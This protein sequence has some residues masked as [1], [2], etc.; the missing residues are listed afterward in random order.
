MPPALRLAA[1]SY[2]GRLDR[3]WL[4]LAAVALAAS[5]VAGVSGVMSSI[6]ASVKMRLNQ[7]VGSADLRVVPSDTGASFDD[8][9]IE[10]VNGWE[11]VD[12][13][14]SVFKKGLG[15]A[16]ID[17]RMVEGE[18]GVFRPEVD[19]HGTLTL[20]TGVTEGGWSDAGVDLIAG[21]MPEAPGE[22]VVDSLTAER[23]SWWYTHRDKVNTRLRGG[24]VRGF[25]VAR[26][27]RDTR[28]T[29]AVPPLPD[30]V[31][32][33]KEAERL[34]LERGLRIGDE[35]EIVY[36]LRENPKLQVVGVMKQ[37]PLGG[38]PR[39]YVP[40]E[41]LHDA[42]REPG[43]LSEISVVLTAGMDPE[44]FEA[45]HR[46][47]LPRGVI[48][49]TTAK[50]TSGVEKNME[51][52]QLGSILGSMLALLSAAFI[53]ATGLTT[54]LGQRQRE[55][56]MLRCIG[57][58]RWQ[59]AGAQ[60]LIGAGIGAFGALIG[61]PVGLLGALGMT[62]ILGP[63]I[64]SGLVLSP[65]FV[66]LS[67]VG[68]V[69][70][71]LLGAA[72]PAWRVARLSPLEGMAMRAQPAS[73]RVVAWT[74]A[75]AFGCVGLTIAI[76]SFPSNTQVMFWGYATVGLPSMMTG[77]FLLG[78]PAVVA[79]AI[80]LGPLLD[81]LLGLPRGLLARSVRATPFRY[82][83]TAGAMMAGLGLMVSIWTNGGAIMNDW[84]GRIT[85]P[86]AFVS[87]V[88][89]TNESQRRLDELPYVEQTCAI[90]LKP[91]E[92]DAFGV[93]ALQNYKTTFIAFEPRPFFDM[94]AIEWVQGDPETAIP[95][96]EQGNAV[97]IAREFLIARGLGVGDTF[98]CTHNGVSHEF[99]IVGVVAS[100][101]IEIV[102][103]FFNIGEEYTE[104]AV[105]AV[106]GSRDD[107]REKFESEAIHLIQLDLAD[108]TDDTQ[109]ISEI[110]ETLFDAGI[111][112]AGSGRR[113]KN[114]IT[115]FVG[116]SLLASSLLA[117]MAML[118]ACFGVANVVIAGIRV[119][120]H[121]F[122]VLRA[123]G[124]EKGLLI[125]LV[126]AEALIIALAACVLGTLIGIQG[127]WAGV[128]MYRGLLGLD[129]SLNPPPLP[130]LA[131]WGIALA[132]TLA[133]ATPA[134]LSLNKKRTRELLG[135]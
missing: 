8:T 12:R 101:G 19:R 118:V 61:V 62:Q 35:I 48:L 111:L 116:G 26:S 97:I 54:D 92:V 65:L 124:A 47:D 6:T 50:V 45:A 130:I 29:E 25:D 66:S 21:R 68:P 128:K 14:T 64:P 106:F 9:L 99:E 107:L 74:A 15:I 94:T 95:R 2:S 91:V 109:A 102:S 89:L 5:L 122:G 18:D 75:V 126:I 93:R 105:H 55:L 76:L 85:F 127:S 103:T 37:P 31:A 34:N 3:L 36:L 98:S 120:S 4:L 24:V 113:I 88:A 51:G 44:S 132:L 40:L 90:T 57:A 133:S 82:G 135:S 52:S 87:G 1:S 43:Q 86:D 53:V 115:R 32:D 46:S 16:F 134:I 63:Q 114:E 56:A 112:D 77:Y 49:Q 121:E 81:K 73:P 22:A 42:T 17:Q 110:R 78:V 69:I 30:E 80:V 58:T 129:L 10:T 39:V 11:G 13:T 119:R 117:V 60:L 125:R 131:G 79:L 33:E 7:T 70:A 71:G 41:T 67:I 72:W 108:G 83:L 96:L 38:R 27:K 123:V 59:M 104:Q 84:L 23:L 28:Y 20:V 100:P